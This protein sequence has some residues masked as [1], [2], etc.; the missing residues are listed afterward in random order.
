MDSGND[1]EGLD[2]DHNFFLDDEVGLVSSG[3]EEVVIP[4]R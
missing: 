1:F 3:N 2:F 4:Q